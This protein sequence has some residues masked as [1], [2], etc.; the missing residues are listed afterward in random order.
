MGILHGSRPC[1]PPVWLVWGRSLEVLLVVSGGH[2]VQF[3][4]EGADQG[5]V[6]RVLR[7]VRGWQAHAGASGRVE[8][9]PEV[10][11]LRGWCRPFGRPVP[12][13]DRR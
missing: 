5:G 9:H 11:A 10:G 6:G 1:R 4:P 12:V 3:V 13:R 2:V 7:S 8:E